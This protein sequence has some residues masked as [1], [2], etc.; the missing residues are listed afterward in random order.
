MV[1]G[2]EPARSGTLRPGA[3]AALAERLAAVE[4]GLRSGCHRHP[5]AVLEDIACLFAAGATITKISAGTGV[6]RHIVHDRLCRAGALEHVVRNLRCPAQEALESRGAALIAAYEA[7]ASLN[8]LAGRAG[9]THDTIRAY[10]V[11]HGIAIRN[12]CRHA[13]EVFE[14]RGDKLAAAY[15]AGATIEALAAGAGIGFQQLK[16]YLVARGVPIHG[17]Q[18]R[19]R[20]IFERRGAELIAAYKAGATITALATEAGV[21]RRTLGTFLEARGVQLRH[22]PGGHR[23]NRRDGG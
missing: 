17:G 18:W 2:M 12:P 21:C 20:T 13:R 22:D 14:A 5:T 10:M 16:R 15:E 6:P 7:G 4:A 1:N 23:K 11:A 19:T 3:G 9:V 8:A